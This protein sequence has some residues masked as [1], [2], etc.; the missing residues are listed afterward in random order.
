MRI[1]LD[2]P[3]PTREIKMLFSCDFP[4]N[5]EK[6]EYVSTDSRNIHK[7]D[8]Y[9]A[10]SN[11]NTDL[12]SHINQAKESGGYIAAENDAI[13]TGCTAS[14]DAI[15]KLAALYK[16]RLE[17]L[18]STVVITGSI[19]K[20]TTKELCAIL[21]SEKYIVHSTFGNQNNRLGI[22]YTLLSAPRD[23]EILLIELGMNHEGEIAPI[24]KLLEPDI[25][26]ITNITNAHIGNLG[27]RKAIA[28][29]KLAVCSGMSDSGITIIPHEEFLLQNGGRSFPRPL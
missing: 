20:T 6:I 26:V 28:N 25:A 15:I 8:L 14:Y 17:K 24:A 12:I 7:G 27:S 9:F 11:S 5:T 4:K 18:K 2:I 22:A 23:T 29:E 16:S 3:L 19:G 13:K 21:L 10:L 1:K